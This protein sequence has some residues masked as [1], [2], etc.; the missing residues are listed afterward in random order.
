MTEPTM[1]EVLT[2]VVE[3]HRPSSKALEGRGTNKE[4]RSARWARDLLWADIHCDERFGVSRDKETLEEV[5]RAAKKLQE[6]LRRISWS[7]QEAVDTEALMQSDPSHWPLWRP[8]DPS[9]LQDAFDTSER[10]GKAAGKVLK[11]HGRRRDVGKTNWRAASV[12]GECRRIWGEEEFRASGAPM[13][14]AL[15]LYS[16]DPVLAAEYQTYVDQVES[17]AP[18]SQKHNVPGPFG[19]FVEDIFQALGIIDKEGNPFPVASAL[20]AW[21]HAGQQKSAK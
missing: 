6:A 5:V 21:K 9:V 14:N 15:L 17:E 19:R 8:G 12:V 16:G 7:T 4:Q 3:K 2:K 18:T 1:V 11:S 13:G 20:R 10:L